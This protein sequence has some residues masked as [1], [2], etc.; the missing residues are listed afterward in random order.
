VSFSKSSHL[1]SEQVIVMK[2][3]SGNWK[4]T[5]DWIGGDD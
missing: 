2:A 1:G 3:T 4:P 5:T